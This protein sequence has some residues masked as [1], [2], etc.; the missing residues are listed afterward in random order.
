MN[1]RLIGL[2]EFQNAYENV[3]RNYRRQYPDTL[4][5]ELMQFL[6]LKGRTLDG[7]ITTALLLQEARRLR[8]G[9]DDAELRE[10]IAARPDFRDDGGFRKQVYVRTLR[11]SGVT[12]A[13]FEEQQRQSILVDKVR[14]VVT[15]GV[16]A[17]DAEARDLYA[18]NNEK[19]SLRFVKFS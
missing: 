15:D 13:E 4:S 11:A 16:E 10:T 2:R 1:D 17:S 6:D 9:V 12:P 5:P 14:G 3:R 18:F 8:L 7:M 19:V